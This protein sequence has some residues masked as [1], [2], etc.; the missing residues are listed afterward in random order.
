VSEPYEI[1][2]KDL[3][4]TNLDQ[5][6]VE[7]GCLYLSL[8]NHLIFLKMYQPA[9]TVHAEFEGWLSLKASVNGF[10]R[11]S[12]IKTIIARGQVGDKEQ[13]RSGFKFLG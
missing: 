4:T 7:I 11:E 13:K 12:L 3:T 5:D 1:L 9:A 2:T 6:D 8:V 10:G